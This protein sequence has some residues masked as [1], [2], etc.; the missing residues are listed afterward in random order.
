MNSRKPKINQDGANFGFLNPEEGY[1][2]QG[3]LVS[4][5]FLKEEV[6]AV[7]TTLVVF[8]FRAHWCLPGPD[9]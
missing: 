3:D 5:A 9:A 4:L 8:V 2:D 7:L 6:A 1:V